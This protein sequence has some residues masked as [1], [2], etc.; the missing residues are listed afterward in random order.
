MKSVSIIGGSVFSL[1]FFGYLFLMFACLAGSVL[2][3]V[4]VVG[5]LS[6][7]IFNA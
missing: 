3:V 5:K 2:G 4:Y 6:R 1:M 7:F